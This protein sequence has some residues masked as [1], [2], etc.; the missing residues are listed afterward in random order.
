MRVTENRSCEWRLKH[1]TLLSDL[2]GRTN[3][4]RAIINQFKTLERQGFKRKVDF[5]NGDSEIFYTKNNLTIEVHYYLST[6][7]R[8]CL[9]VIID[10][11]G[12]R[13][14]IFDCSSFDRA[15]ISLLRAEIDSIDSAEP[16]QKQL[17]LYVEFLEK[18]ANELWH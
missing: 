12:K 16:L 2:K 8:Y 5:R 9:E 7:R 17:G 15:E 13:A 10:R 1:D 6:G 11:N 4:Q 3:M 14:N 18:H